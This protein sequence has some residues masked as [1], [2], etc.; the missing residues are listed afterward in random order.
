MGTE[1]VFPRVLLVVYNPTIA[2]E[3]GR[4]LS[5]IFHWNDP[6][7]LA[8]QYAADLSEASHGYCNYEIVERVEIDGFPI[9]ID[10]FRYAAGDFLSAWRARRGFHNPDW[11]DYRR[12]LADLD[13]VARVEKEQIDEVWLFAFPYAGFYESRMAG[14]GAFWC[15]A[16]PLEGYEGASRRFVIMGFNYERGVGEMLEAHG[17]RAESIMSHVFRETRG[18]ANLWERFTRYDK[19]HPG[20]AEVGNIH[21]APNSRRDYDW[22]NQETVPSRCD[23]WYRFPDLD[24][25]ARGVNSREWG[26]GDI[27]LHHLWW[28]RHLPHV[29]GA[30]D[31]VS[32]NWWEYIT[33]PNLVQ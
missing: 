10:G 16:P 20:R 1:A 15:N 24:A 32:N 27:R 26:N 8:R 4:K 25:P 18:R 17:H 28:Y 5:T 19:T 11:A 23:T 30:S 6:D 33:N 21:F 31:G 22:G 3:G 14:P 12:I 2:S 29:A 9:K 13:I 7:Q